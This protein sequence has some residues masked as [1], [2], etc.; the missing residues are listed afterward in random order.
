ML[1]RILVFFLETVFSL[2]IGAALLRGYMNGVRANMTAQPGYFV[3]AITDWI[4]KPL[5]R[6][7]PVA[8]AKSRIDWASFMA[9][10]LLALLFAVL[11][12]LLFGVG[13]WANGPTALLTL[14]G[15]SFK[16]LLRVALQTTM[17]LLIGYVIVSWVQP[18]SPA[19]SLLARLTEP[20]LA[21]LRRVVPL[22]GGLDL[23]ALLLALLL[24][25]SLMLLG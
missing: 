8:V 17:V 4:V 7:L 21:P 1:I 25:I 20:M 6:V 13:Y 24:Q 9:A 22:V 16:M 2:L 5:R 14:L 19:H 3:M 18:G 11:W 10:A 12:D 23:S 15:F